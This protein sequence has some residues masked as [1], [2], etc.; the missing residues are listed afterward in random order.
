MGSASEN[1][2]SFRRMQSDEP[3]TVTASPR[4]RS[5]LRYDASHTMDRLRSTFIAAAED[6]HHTLNNI[7]PS[8]SNLS[9]ESEDEDKTA[10][11]SSRMRK[12]H[13]V[14][15]TAATAATKQRHKKSWK[16]SIQSGFGQIPAVVLIG[17]FHLM[18]GIPFGVR[19]VRWG[20]SICLVVGNERYSGLTTHSIRSC[21][22]IFL[23]CCTM[24]AISLLVGEV[25]WK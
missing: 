8:S 15:S 24:V 21:R 18:I 12:S 22:Y 17:M 5:T 7:P 20:Y 9:F 23:L 3:N 1:H 10:S 6:P 25:T 16:K 13:R 11:S 2:V 4:R 14:P 19:L